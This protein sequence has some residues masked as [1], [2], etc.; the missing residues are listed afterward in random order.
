MPHSGGIRDELARLARFRLRVSH[1]GS[2]RQR[3]RAAVSTAL[4][5]SLSLHD[6]RILP[7]GVVSE[8]FVSECEADS[9]GGDSGV[10][11]VR[12]RI[13]GLL[14]PEFGASG[15]LHSG[16]QATFE[17][18]TRTDRE[19]RTDCE[20]FSLTCD[21]DRRGRRLD[22]T[23]VSLRLDPVVAGSHRTRPHSVRLVWSSRPFTHQLLLTSTGKIARV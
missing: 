13:L 4:R 3:P 11:M 18:H 23:L 19:T 6:R 12:Y 7:V 10:S 2:P 16:R 17:F 8:A 9:D 5:C 22:E 20:D 14:L 21:I 1:S 15:L